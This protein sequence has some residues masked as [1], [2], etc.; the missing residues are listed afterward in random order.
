MP[1]RIRVGSFACHCQVLQRVRCGPKNLRQATSSAQVSIPPES[2]HF[3]DL[4]Q[5]PQQQARA[6][7]LIKGVLPVPRQLFPRSGVD[8][9]SSLYLA[10]TTQEPTAPKNVKSIDASAADYVAWKARSAATRRQ[11]LREGLVE[12]H[13]RKT[14]MDRRRRARSAFKRAESERAVSQPM[15]EDE[16]LTISSINPMMT[17][18]CLANIPDPNFKERIARKRKHVEDKERRKIEERRNALHSLYM[19]ARDFIVTEAALNSKVDEVF[20]EEWFKTNEGRSIWDKEKHPQDTIRSLLRD[21]NRSGAKAGL[22]NAGYTSITMNRV[23][24][25]GE[26]LT[27]GKI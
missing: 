12:L 8:K 26:E 19:N 1:P 25:I 22:H 23:R 20:D 3:I 5:A 14:V 10:N 21:A 27:G 13:H 7:R 4:P 16:R 9:T 11:N 15:R 6:R 18:D 24:R 17:P 2:P